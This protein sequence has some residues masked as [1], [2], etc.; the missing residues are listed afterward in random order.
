MQAARHHHLSA[1]RS[2]E[3]LILKHQM[4]AAL[5]VETHQ[6]ATTTLNHVKVTQPARSLLL[7]G[8]LHASKQQDRQQRCTLSNPG[9]KVCVKRLLM[10]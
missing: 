1:A 2:D 4:L 9:T 7:L 10:L 6:Q 5:G 8:T 3:H